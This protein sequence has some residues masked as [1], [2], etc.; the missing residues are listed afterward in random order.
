MKR[1][2][3]VP[4]NVESVG[5]SLALIALITASIVPLRSKAH[6]FVSQENHSS[7]EQVS[8]CLPQ[9]VKRS[10]NVQREISIRIFFMMIFILYKKMD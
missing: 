10:P 2:P 1:T 8:A 6:V 4:T 7:M 3:C 5:K 9:P